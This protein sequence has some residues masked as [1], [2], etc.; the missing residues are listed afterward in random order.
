MAKLNILNKIYAAGPL[1][2]L[3]YLSISDVDANLE[4]FLEIFSINL[5]III[6]YF[7]MI[8][9]PSLMG[10]G[11]IFVAGLIND[12]VMGFPLGISS[13]SYLIVCFVGNY[14]RNKSVNTTL[15]SDWFTFFLALLFSNVLFF[16]LINNFSDLAIPFS[17][18]GYNTFFTLFLFPI[19]WFL[20]NIYQISFIGSQDA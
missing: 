3:Y 10:T 6:I 11:H 13:L 4:N 17:K 14:V 9:R 2:L 18:M 20:F 1:I 19:F 16:S 12:V 8:K 7:W 5:Q 15:A